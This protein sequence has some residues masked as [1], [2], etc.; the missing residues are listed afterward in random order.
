MKP[1]VSR[2]HDPLRAAP[3]QDTYRH[4]SHVWIM[5]K[6]W[7]NLKEFYGLFVGPMVSNVPSPKP[8]HWT[9]DFPMFFLVSRAIGTKLPWLFSSAS[10]AW[11]AWCHQLAWKSHHGHGW[12][13]YTLW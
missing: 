11:A 8:S 5:G 2:S 6:F 7:E 13:S 9:N 4:K 10:S 3:L 12:E 1:T